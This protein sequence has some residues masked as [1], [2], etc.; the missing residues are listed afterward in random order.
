MKGLTV[1]PEITS[2]YNE[3][4]L[5]SKGVET[6]KDMPLEDVRELIL[7]TSGGKDAMVAAQ[8]V[9]EYKDKTRQDIQIQDKTRQD[10]T[11]QDKTR[12]DIQIQA[13]M[14]PYPRIQY[15]EENTDKKYNDDV[16]QVE[17]F[18]KEL[19]IPLTIL[20]TPQP[21]LEVGDKDSCKVCK[22]TR[23]SLINSYLNNLPELEEGKRALVTGYTTA[24]L[25]AYVQLMQLATN[26][27][28][29]FDQIKDPQVRIGFE[30]TLNKFKVSQQLQD[31]NLIIRPLLGFSDAE[32]LQIVNEK[33]IPRL[34]ISCPHI[35]TKFK[36]KSMEAGS[37]VE[38]DGMMNVTYEGLIKL[39]ERSGI[40]LPNDIGRPL[41]NNGK[42]KSDFIDC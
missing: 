32:I 42:V 24:D 36:R 4:P 16:E 27:T 3:N 8:V 13:C 37:L 40:K 21:D 6:M 22:S 34:N 2:S 31:G 7:L 39:L 14:V 23:L 26:F 12:Q 11:R 17:K 9:A 15:I 30:R 28:L 19:G 10:K 35:G 1:T 5:I 25:L 20:H 29:D 38:G 41:V 18:L 33:N